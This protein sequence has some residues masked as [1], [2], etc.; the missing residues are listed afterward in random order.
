M[1]P[2]L[3]FGLPALGAIC[4]VLLARREWLALWIGS[5]LGLAGMAAV[6]LSLG[7]GGSDNTGLGLAISQRGGALVIAAG[8]A[9]ALLVV[10]APA[11]VNR[12]AF[13]TLGLTGLAA[14]VAIVA[15]PNLDLVVLVLLVL[16]VLHA[17]MPGKRT[18][19]E[20]LQAP[21]TG[22]VL[23]AAGLYFSRLD[24][25][26]LE[27]RIA[28]VAL[29]TGAMATVGAL[30]YLQ[31]LD[32]DET[33]AASPIAWA[34]FIGPVVVVAVLTQARSLVPGAENA[35]GA[36]VLG[37]GLLNVVWATLAA[38]RVES[39]ID[40]WRYSFLAD[41]GLAICA[42]GL[43]VPDGDAAAQ[44]VLF[45]I[46]LSRLPLYMWSRPALRER[47]S[48]DRPLNL[49]VAAALAGSAPFGGFPARVLLLHASTEI[50]WP[51]ALVLALAMLLWL[52]SS[53][54]LGRSLGRPRGRALFGI[55]LV[56]GV[57]ALLGLWPGL[58]LSGGVAT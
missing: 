52:P 26:L 3:A 7:G 27:T 51:L 2:E 19:T 21:A 46:L 38:W 6:L 41:L 23:L 40:A 10:L 4:A 12:A 9:L 50:Y 57:S 1:E 17:A 54:R 56:L 49:W 32:K 16:A 43:P 53:L 39:E 25:T 33:A 18:L 15:A 14:L 34:G 13:L 55:G 20:R 44:L 35:F 11:R 37:F 28:A 42:L 29:V 30:P 48:N 24:G 5:L 31:V 8:A 22:A 58:F 36:L 47:T 45:G